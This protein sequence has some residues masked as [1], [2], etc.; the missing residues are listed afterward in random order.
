MMIYLVSDENDFLMMICE[1]LAGAERY[2]E[3]CGNPNWTIEEEEAC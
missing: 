3:K 1:T 2:I